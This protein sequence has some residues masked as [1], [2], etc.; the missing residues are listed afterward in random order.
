MERASRTGEDLGAL[1]V[2]VEA[3]HAGRAQPCFLEP[4]YRDYLDHRYPPSLAGEVW[5]GYNRLAGD[6]TMIVLPM[7]GVVPGPIPWFNG[8][9]FFD[10]NDVDP[11]DRNIWRDLWA[12]MD[13]IQAEA[14]K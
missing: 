7:G 2:K 14:Q 9:E 8:E 10:R 12:V 5:L 11:D 1:M 3:D 6:R 4:A 13:S